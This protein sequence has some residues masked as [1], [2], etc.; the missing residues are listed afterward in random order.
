MTQMST[1]LPLLFIISSQHHHN[2]FPV[3]RTK[4]L[5]VMS[6]QMHH[7]KDSL[8]LPYWTSV[9]GGIPLPIAVGTMRCGAEWSVYLM[10]RESESE[11]FM[12]TKVVKKKDLS[13]AGGFLHYAAFTFRLFRYS[14]M[15]KRAVQACEDEVRLPTTPHHTVSLSFLTP[16]AQRRAIGRG[17][18][19]E[20]LAD[21]T[22]EASEAED[23]DQPPEQG[24]QQPEREESSTVYVLP[25]HS[26]LTRKASIIFLLGDTRVADQARAQP[27]K[28]N[29]NLH[30]L[31]RT[32]FPR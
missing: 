4:L 30:S 32:S 11:Q 2:F 8:E 16:A 3:C 5:C 9:V 21:S 15:F 6:A 20:S 28:G 17:Q 31:R 22:E 18:Q 29:P 13:E 26:C 14:Q 19:N 1:C 10:W 23:D 12:W 7:I 27:H 24:T 25:L